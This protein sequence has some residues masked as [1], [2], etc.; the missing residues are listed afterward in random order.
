MKSTS[1]SKITCGLARTKLS[2]K[3]SAG[4][5]LPGYCL[6]LGLLSTTLMAQSFTT[7]TGQM[8]AHRQFHKATLLG[9][10]Q[11]LVTG[12][13][14][15]SSPTGFGGLASS[16]LYNPATNAFASTGAMIT[17]RAYH[18][19]TLLPTGQV[20]IAGGYDAAQQAVASAELYN[21]ATG[22][23]TATGSMTTPRMNH[24]ATLLP[25]GL[26]L[27]A[28]G[29]NANFGTPVAS[30]ELYNPATGVFTAL[31][32]SMTAARASQTATL[33]A[34]GLVLIAGGIND[35]FGFVVLASAELYNPAAG[36]FTATGSMTTAR[37]YHTATL[38]QGPHGQILIAGGSGAV[39]GPLSS[40]EL[41]DPKAGVFSASGPMTTARQ[42][43]TA[44]LLAHGGQTG[45]QVLITGGFGTNR[46]GL[47]SSL[48]TAELYDLKTGTLTVVPSSTT[49]SRQAHTAT[50]LPSGQILVA[51]GSGFVF[52][53]SYSTSELF[54]STG[55]ICTPGTA[56]CGWHYGDLFTL[57]QNWYLSGS[58][59]GALVTSDY[60]T[61]YGLLGG[62]FV[63]GSPQGYSMIFTSPDTLLAFLPQFGVAAP[64]ND[65]LL[66]PTVS[67]SG[68]FGGDVVAL[69]LN[70]DF[71]DAGA[72][73]GSSMLP[74]G[75]LTLC[76]FGPLVSPLNG[77]A[78]RQILATANTALGGGNTL[79]SIADLDPLTSSLSY[80]FSNG[81]P[82]G[83]AQQHLVNG[84]CK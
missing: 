3:R 70:V 28:G 49:N 72:M 17:G 15:L 56:G 2:G 54:N 50:L 41:Y 68:V 32:V 52:G 21:P 31:A 67:S 61:V 44:T 37:A 39:G 13:Y 78:V 59:A 45:G 65:N 35:Q 5:G 18:T 48:G 42:W 84:A 60:G 62:V 57:F 83:F 58:Y 22:M 66:D 34:N 76:N 20:L 9:N 30:A 75:N 38:T 33:L 55:R 4:S 53:S 77:M 82:D 26:V 10:G 43:H 40:T 80:A 16:E 51:G 11:V 74:F 29:N 1:H 79:L 8:A 14:D 7:T 71:S 46:F 6:F 63:V 81:D 24:T 64:L 23:S 27:I 19:A 69:K 73:E 12:G 36:A 47:F 25:N